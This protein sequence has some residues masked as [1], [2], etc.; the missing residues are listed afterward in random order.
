MGQCADSVTPIPP[1]G[2]KEHGK[3]GAGKSKRRPA[4]AERLKEQSLSHTGIDASD[5][6]ASLRAA[7]A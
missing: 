3:A 2:Y 6:A 1:E 5:Y 7:V 4:E